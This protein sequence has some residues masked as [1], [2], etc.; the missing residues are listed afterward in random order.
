MMISVIGGR[1]W[2]RWEGFSCV[3]VIL[4]SGRVM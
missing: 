3:V 2:L 4:I 1:V